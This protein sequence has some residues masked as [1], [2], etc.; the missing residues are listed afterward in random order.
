MSTTRPFVPQEPCSTAIR[1]KGW[2]TIEGEKEDQF[3]HDGRAQYYNNLSSKLKPSCRLTVKFL[4]RYGK[5]SHRL[6]VN[7]FTTG[8]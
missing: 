1:I 6:L 7:L 3:E 8:S 5:I 4:Y 2:T